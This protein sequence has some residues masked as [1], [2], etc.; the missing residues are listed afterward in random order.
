MTINDVKELLNA[1]VCSGHTMLYDTVKTGCGSDDMGDVMAYIKK[2]AVLLTGNLNPDVIRTSAM[3][4]VICVV[5]VR[6][7]IPTPETLKV[8]EEMNISVLST[9]L[10]MF[11]ACGILYSEGLGRVDTDK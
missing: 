5:Y 4:D 7:K 2:K 9:N 10:R 11:E 6:G 8:A 3:M 1:Q